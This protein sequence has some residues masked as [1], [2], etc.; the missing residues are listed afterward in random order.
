MSQRP[1]LSRLASGIIALAAL[2][3]PA[4]AFAQAPPLSEAIVVGSWTFR[5]SAE[6]RIRGE[7][8]RDT[9]GLCAAFGDQPF[10]L[11]A[12]LAPFLIAFVII[13]ART[14]RGGWRWR[15]GEED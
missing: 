15:W 14:T 3:A 7:Y 8:R 11:F 2:G 1:T 9:F 10:R 5:P 4:A 12:S 6:I 13:T